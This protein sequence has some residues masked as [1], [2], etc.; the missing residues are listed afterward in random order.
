M[1]DTWT[2]EHIQKGYCLPAQ[3][4][5]PIDYAVWHMRDYMEDT[6]SLQ[7][8][9][10][11]RVLPTIAASPPMQTTVPTVT[12]ILDGLSLI[13]WAAIQ[14]ILEYPGGAKKW[15]L[16]HPSDHSKIVVK[17]LGEPI[18][19]G[20]KNPVEINLNLSW[21]SRDRLSYRNQEVVDLNPVMRQDLLDDTTLIPQK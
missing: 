17:T 6:C 11:P 15:M 18:T 13:R 7:D 14:A 4:G 5:Q 19:S 12:Q 1:G 3:L 9:G 16:D 2:A 10:K 20:P 21:I 8:I